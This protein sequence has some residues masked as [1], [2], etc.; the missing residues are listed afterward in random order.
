MVIRRSRGGGGGLMG[1]ETAAPPPRKLVGF[2][3]RCGARLAFSPNLVMA[4]VSQKRNGES[5]LMDSE[6]AEP[7]EITDS[8]GNGRGCAITAKS[9]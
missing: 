1:E 2:C 5:F 8:P 4:R 3:R 9:V 7:L 6:I